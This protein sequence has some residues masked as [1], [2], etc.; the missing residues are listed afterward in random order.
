MNVNT[1][2]KD[3]Y[4]DNARRLNSLIAYS[5]VSTLILQKCPKKEE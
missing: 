1:V 5:K 2:L 3:V 4:E